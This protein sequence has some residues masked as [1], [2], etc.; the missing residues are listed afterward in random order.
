MKILII[1]TCEWP[2]DE[3]SLNTAGLGGSE[4]WCVQLSK[5]FVKKG[6]DVTILCNSETHRAQSGVQ[7]ISYNEI[8]NIISQQKY[9][10]IIISR[11]YSNLLSGIDYFKTSDNVFIQAH[12]V[13][14]YGDGINKIK[15]FPCFKGVVTLSAYQERCIH[16]NCGLDWKYMTRI[17]NGIDP[18][19]FENLNF[20]SNNKRLLFSSDYRRCGYILK[21]CIIPKLINLGTNNTGTDFCSYTKQDEIE[22]NDNTQILGSLSKER[23][24]QEMS[25]RYCWFY[26]GVFNETFCITMI[27][28]IMCENDIVAPLTYGMSSVIE[29]FVDDVSMKHRFDRNEDEFWMAVDEASNKINESI[30]NHEK[31]AELRKE[32]K[33]YVLSNYTWDIIADKWLKLV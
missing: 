15:S 17:G 14:I 28:N 8:N 1:N 26:P 5:A 10:S 29:P 4:T 27:E 7:Y 31:N 13:L 22:N 32:L 19:L 20:T 18:K 24:Y 9:D 11:D 25:N 6:Q 12:D 3:D 30:N 33:N 23:L 2:F 16:N 21:D